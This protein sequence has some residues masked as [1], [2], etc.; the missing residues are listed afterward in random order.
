MNLLS[1]KRRAAGASADDVAGVNAQE[2][3]KKIIEEDYLPQRI[4]YPG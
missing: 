3:F 2:H 1:V 4:F